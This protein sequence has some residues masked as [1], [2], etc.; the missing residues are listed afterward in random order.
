MTAR[1]RARGGALPWRGVWRQ[2]RVD[3]A[4]L[5]VGLVV[6]AV[7]AFMSAVVPQAIASVATEEVQ[8]AVSAPEVRV[9]VVV[10]VPISDS[11]GEGYYLA[12]ST[13]S[14]AES[15]KGV[16]DN[17]MPPT[18]SKV[19][20]PG[21]TVIET[22]ELKAGEI[23][24]RPGRARFIYV[25][26]DDG[27]D[28]EWVA[29][30]APAATADAT[31]ELNADSEGLL[32]EVGV[33]EASAAVM[34]VHVG[35]SLTVFDP[36]DAPLDVTL[37]GIFRAS[38]AGD[39][40]WHVAPTLM[41][42]QVIDGSAAVAV[43]G[44]MVSDT[45]LPFA[46]LAMFPQ[47]LSRTYTYSVVPSLFTSAN[48]TDLDTEARGLASGK[49]SF[50]TLGPQVRVT[51]RLDRVLDDALAR[52]DAASAQSS[53]VLI[54]ILAVAVAV[55]LL[56]AKL[57]VE[58]RTPV[59]SQFRSRGGTLAAIGAAAAAESV[60]VAAFGGVIGAGLARYATHG[61]TPWAWL[62]PPLVIA[63]LAPPVLAVWAAA[64]VRTASARASSARGGGVSAVRVRRIAG[65]VLLVVA[66]AGSLITLRARGIGAS[67][68][69]V[70]SDIPVL[71]APV[72]VT[73]AVTVLIVRAQPRLLRAARSLGARSLGAVPLLAASRV[74]ASGV[75][76]AA[77][78]M[79]GAIAMMSASLATTVRDGQS[80]AAWD[81]VGADVAVTA[82]AQGGL[83]E[84]IAALD[85]TGFDD[86]G[87]YDNDRLT[88][89]TATLATGG[90]VI[91][92]RVDER[93]SVVAVDANAMEQLLA[94][95]GVSGSNALAA[96]TTGPTADGSVPV[97][98]TGGARNWSGVTLTWGDESLP[99]EWA[100]RSPVLPRQLPADGATV[101]IDRAALVAAVGHDV[102]ANFAWA[103]GS[104]AGQRVAAVVSAAHASDD[105][106][107][108]TREGWLAERRSAPVTRGL[109]WLFVGAVAVAALLAV[110]AVMVMA[111][112]GSSQ[113]MRSIARV[114]VVGAPRSAAH[115]VAWLEVAVPSVV[116]S[117]V[118]LGV[119][120][121]L[122][123]V[124]VVPLD[125]ESVTGARAA[126]PFVA[127]WWILALALVLGVVAR[128]SVALA[129]WSHGR[130]RLGAL[131]R[132]G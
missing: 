120:V 102:P 131:M 118:G 62:L 17:G 63:A 112:S 51:T 77:L 34:G 86:S 61:A 92:S 108:I 44:L 35:D 32:I 106:T 100:G 25:K 90:Q 12:P 10:A 84:G 6:I 98:V 54:G 73:L 67:Q 85:G 82:D 28:V 20:A 109:E 130:E 71:A 124:L 15:A 42:P 125:L 83:P 58:R 37:A 116:A 123:R 105:T 47:D 99:V 70:L 122:A 55:E 24:G 97:L 129:T 9:D 69:A 68:G 81:A 101:V 87:L 13:A 80:A 48:A 94:Q 88:V 19:L 121:W 8:A 11:R 126:P 45:S 115:R 53:V 104:D 52:V 36:D 117:A 1:H 29:G 26:S 4:P 46:R 132:V 49:I 59:L 7:A 113:R 27:P 79:A 74:R 128:L 31:D 22:Q 33:S 119:G 103:T 14:S 72:L 56:A 41:N 95:T 39:A 110:L 16:V 114:R 89:A 127:A 38:D 93:V 30:R 76:M 75:A 18:L 66:A 111:A 2:S 78:V 96:L 57:V 40:A 65:E 5:A 107:V 64:K 50:G 21:V 60:L 23:A 43:V 91:G 3:V